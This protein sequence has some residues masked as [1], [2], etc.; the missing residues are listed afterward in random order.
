[1]KA[2]SRCC[3]VGRYSNLVSLSSM[4]CWAKEY[5]ILDMPAPLTRRLAPVGEEDGGSVVLIHYCWT[6]LESAARRNSHVYSTCDRASEISTS[7]DSVD[8]LMAIF[9][10]PDF[11]CII[12]LPNIIATPVTDFPVTDKRRRR[13]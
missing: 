3:P 6:Y 9:C 11:T 8:N 1:M 12:A 13:R 10:L 2:R 5:L 7:S 4:H